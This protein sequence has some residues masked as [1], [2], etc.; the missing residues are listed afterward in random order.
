[1]RKV[2]SS[3][4]KSTE[5]RFRASMI[6]SGLKG[7]TVRP[8]MEFSP[9]FAFEEKRVIVFIDG[10]FWH[11]CPICN[12]MPASNK[13]YWTKK[14]KRN[15]ERDKKATTNLTEAGWTVLRFWEHQI[16]SELGDCIDAL[17]AVL[18]S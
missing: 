9:D 6:Q 3:G 16:K 8:K 5:W 4:N 1:M 11:S 15:I 17:K 7:W 18:D 2:K 13:E 12:K 14:F 10:C